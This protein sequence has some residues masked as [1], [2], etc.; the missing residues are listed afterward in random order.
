MFFVWLGRFAPITNKTASEMSS[1]LN[2][3]ENNIIVLS[4]LSKNVAPGSNQLVFVS[5]PTSML[6]IRAIMA[7]ELNGTVYTIFLAPGVLVASQVGQGHFVTSHLG[8]KM[9]SVTWAT[10]MSTK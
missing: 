1:S 7:K 3:I 6:R 8:N 5:G 10:K 2:V 4:S 9:A